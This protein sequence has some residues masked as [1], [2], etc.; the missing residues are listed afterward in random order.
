MLSS[1]STLTRGRGSAS[2]G[3]RLP[4]LPPSLRQ[5]QHPRQAES[6]VHSSKPKGTSWEGSLGNLSENLNANIKW[7]RQRGADDSMARR[8]PLTRGRWRRVPRRS[9]TGGVVGGAGRGEHMVASGVG[10]RYVTV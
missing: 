5:R 7:R 6:I 3:R 1:S 2:G 8:A 4:A 9:L 10:F